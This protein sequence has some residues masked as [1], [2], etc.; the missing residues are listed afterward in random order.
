MTGDVLKAT[1]VNGVISAY[2]NDVFLVSAT[3]TTYQAGA[4]G[5]GLNTYN[6]TDPTTYGLSSFTAS[7]N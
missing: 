3:D 5:F 2:L 1:N 6:D 4:P 7:S